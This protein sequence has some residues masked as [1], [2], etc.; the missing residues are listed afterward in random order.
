L[1]IERKTHRTSA[2]LLDK[3]AIGFSVAGTEPDINPIIRSFMNIFT[4]PNFIPF[5]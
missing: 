3:I 5:T 2:K 1:L 4:K